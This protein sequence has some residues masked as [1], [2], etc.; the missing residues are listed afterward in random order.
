[1]MDKY[2]FTDLALENSQ[3]DRTGKTESIYTEMGINIIKT[4][5]DSQKDNGILP[6]DVYYTIECGGLSYI[7]E[8][9]ILCITQILSR[10]IRELSKKPDCSSAQFSVLVIGLGN[11]KICAD[12]LGD[13]CCDY[14]N[15]ICDE[16]APARLSAF[17]T[18]VSAQTGM[19]TSLIA[20]CA[21]RVV[22]ADLIICIDSLCAK[23]A[24]RLGSVIQL[25]ACGIFPGSA[26]TAK[27]DEI[28]FSSMSVPVI[29]IGI[30][31]VINAQTLASSFFDKK[32]NDVINKLSGLYVTPSSCDTIIKNGAYIISE[33][34][35]NAFKGF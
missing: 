2:I 14:I 25:G 12:S 9:R 4:T 7:D 1:M 23:D 32:H 33:S 8:D 28:S 11:R 16:N 35:N 19:S 34:I 24:S 17:K 18:G 30:P 3:T 26:L 6:R 22:N 5:F 20:E 15:V 31:T 29:S 13:M 27:R 21:K 10:K